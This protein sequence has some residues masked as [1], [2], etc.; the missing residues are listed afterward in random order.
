MSLP[1]R[2]IVRAPASLR[3]GGSRSLLRSAAYHPIVTGRAR[4][5]SSSA[6]GPVTLTYDLHEP[7]RPVADRETSPILFLHG[8]FGSKKN[9]RS[10]SK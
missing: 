4:C 6:D 3:L 7:P 2:M 5:Y 9:Y 8:L 10:I 1:W